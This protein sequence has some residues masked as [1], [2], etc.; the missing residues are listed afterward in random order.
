MQGLSDAVTAIACHPTQPLAAFLCR[1]GIIQVW[2]YELKLLMNLREFTNIHNPTLNNTTNNNT[3]N[4]NN[5]SGGPNHSSNNNML[6]I[7]NK[8]YKFA[9]DL[10]YHPTNHGQYLAVGF[11]TGSVKILST[12]TLQD[13]QSF[14]PSVD[15]IESITF[16]PSGVYL[17]ATDE[18]FHVLLF[19]RY[20]LFYYFTLYSPHTHLLYSLYY[21]LLYYIEK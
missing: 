19:K 18:L 21:T 8:H 20:F 6:P 15:G 14:S 2:N 12:E 3:N 4:N 13:L 7:T 5:T 9:R 17:A 1:S 10:K 11:S 16:S